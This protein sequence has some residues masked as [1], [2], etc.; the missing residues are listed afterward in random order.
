MN[1]ILYPPCDP[2]FLIR[3]TRMIVSSYRHWV[4]ASLWPMTNPDSVLAEEVFYAPFILASAGTEEDPILNYGNQKALELWQMDWDAF[5]KTPGRKTA[6]TMEQDV[7][8]QFLA[9][10]KKQGYID[11][12]SGI[13]ISSTG[14]RFEIQHAT[15]WNLIDNRGDYAGQAAVFRNWRYLP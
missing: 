2:N 9:T 12:Y 4:K 11:N 13:R 8:G 7:R 1:P 6:E 10:V 15:V 5:T 3:Q 14:K